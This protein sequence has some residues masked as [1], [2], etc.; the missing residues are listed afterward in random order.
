MRLIRSSPASPARNLALDEALL[1]SGTPTF[2]M[3]SW[4]PAGY[5]LG[6]FQ[7]FAEHTVPEGYE[8]V[9]RP[10]GGGAI[11]H[12]GELTLSWVGAKE[13]VDD[14]YATINDIVSRALREGFGIEV[15]KGT[16]APTAAPAGLCFDAH[17]CYDLCAGGGASGCRG[18]RPEFRCG[19]AQGGCRD[20]SRQFSQ[21]A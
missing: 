10:T 17:T 5:S 1:R 11:A 7:R 6:F 21:S 14:V 9:R 3:Y 18:W 16:G 19:E 8:V 4:N 12:T 13:R 2:R 15:T 20:G